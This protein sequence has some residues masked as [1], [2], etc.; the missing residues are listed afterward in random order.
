[1]F[2][3]PSSL[4]ISSCSAGYTPTPPRTPSCP[5]STCTCTVH[6][7]FI[8]NRR[9]PV[10]TPSPPPL[11]YLLSSTLCAAAHRSSRT[12]PHVSPPSLHSPLVVATRSRRHC[13]GAVQSE[14]HGHLSSHDASG[15]RQHTQL[16]PYRVRV[17]PFLPTTSLNASRICNIFHLDFILTM[18]TP[19]VPCSPLAR[20]RASTR[21]L[22]WSW[23]T[24]DDNGQSFASGS[25][26]S[27]AVLCC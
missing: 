24:R 25:Q 18:P 9:S 26:R 7:K 2:W 10:I 14:Q 21:R 12:D 20:T 1:M 17:T 4:K 22:A 3:T 19:A 8:P 27:V 6:T 15:P 5:P 16:P 11:C 13:N 23:W